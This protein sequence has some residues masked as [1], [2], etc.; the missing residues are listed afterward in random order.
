[1]TR[2]VLLAALL[3]GCAAPKYDPPKPEMP[4]A[5]KVEAPFREGAPND[6]APKGRWWARFSDPKL[7]ELMDKA[8]AGNPTLAAAYQRLAQARATLASVGAAQ[9]PQVAAAVRA[10]RF[11]I[12]E[13]RP[14][15]NN[16]SP[17]FSTTQNDFA[18]GLAA[19][20]ELDFAGRV[21]SLVS[22]ARASY[23]QSAADLENVKLLLTADLATA[24][25]NLRQTDIELDV[26]AKAIELQQRSLG[27][28]RT[29]H[30]L[31]AGTGLDVAQQQALIDN[32]LTQ[33]DILKRQRAQFQHALASLTGTP[34]PLFSIEP[35]VRA[36]LTPPAVPIGVPS[37]ILERRPD[38]AAAERAMAAANAQVGV[39]NAAFYPSIVLGATLGQQSRNIDA[40]FERPSLVWSLGVNL[41]QPLIDGGRIRANFDFSKAGYE[42]AVANYRRVVLGAM[43][44]AE[45]GIIGL[46]ALERASDQS[47]IS[48]ASQQRVLDLVNTRY[49]G[50]VASPLEV[51]VAQQALL[52]NQRLAAQLVGQRLLTT[53]FLVKALGGDWE[54]S[55]TASPEREGPQ[56]LSSRP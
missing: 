38:V 48:V 11:R 5:W 34:A 44:E 26:L 17:N 54:G 40:L 6:A 15:T 47:R 19:S 33:V 18:V 36:E 25:F 49:E 2:G 42:I 27:I 52:N 28:A 3:A 50:G 23:E 24:Y 46:A 32:T 13:N 37:D 4:V 12:T 16:A 9:Y 10:Q 51:I 31:G 30:D 39:A 53:V 45:D 55:K 21:S 41:L 56:T 43:Q 1:M 20:Y 29:R 14:L 7:D 35:D 8:L 22:G